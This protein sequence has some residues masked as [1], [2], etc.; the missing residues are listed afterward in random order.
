MELSS[1]FKQPVKTLK[2]LGPSKKLALKKVL[3][4]KDLY[5]GFE[6]QIL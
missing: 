3:L 5:G 6:E 4:K 1:G 2:S